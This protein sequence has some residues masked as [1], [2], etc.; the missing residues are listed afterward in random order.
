[1]IEPATRLWSSTK[2]DPGVGRLLS[3]GSIRLLTDCFHARHSVRF[4]RRRFIGRRT[5]SNGA[6]GGCTWTCME[7]IDTTKAIKG[8]I[9]K[10][11]QFTHTMYK[12]T[13]N[14][15]LERM[16]QLPSSSI[17]R[18]AGSFRLLS[19]VVVIAGWALFSSEYCTICT[20]GR[21]HTNGSLNISINH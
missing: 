6:A 17:R 12:Q 4:G 16:L 9:S 18:R 8:A 19:V 21:W 20:V 1:M 14:Y 13:V 15:L 5:W 3:D 7:L 11:K 2:Q 10:N